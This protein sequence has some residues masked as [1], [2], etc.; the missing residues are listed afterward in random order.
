MRLYLTSLYTQ[1][2]N[3]KLICW[4]TELFAAIA[5][6]TCLCMLSDS[7]THHALHWIN[8]GSLVV[9]SF[10]FFSW[11]SFAFSCC[12]HFIVSNARSS[13]IGAIMCTVHKFHGKVNAFHWAF[14][15]CKCVSVFLFIIIYV[16][17]SDSY[18]MILSNEQC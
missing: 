10:S 4:Y 2:I 5:L 6:Y 16:L 18:T 3:D 11:F 8:R 15:A 1:Q 9:K 7:H 17:L 14:C 13:G 12:C